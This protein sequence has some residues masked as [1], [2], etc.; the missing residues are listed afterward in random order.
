MDDDN[1]FD[2]K[3]ITVHT[4]MR[5]G[6]KVMTMVYGFGIEYDIEKILKHFQKTFHCTGNIHK[7]EK[8][9]EIIQLTGNNKREVIDFLIREEIATMD[10]IISMGI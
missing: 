8:F 1:L 9:G 2:S 4:K 10:N 3:K 6:R 5:T 7:D